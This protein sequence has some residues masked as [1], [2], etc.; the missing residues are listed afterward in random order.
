M[1]L[2]IR[3]VVVFIMLCIA[4]ISLARPVQAFDPLEKTCD[5]TAATSSSSVCQDNSAVNPE[6]LVDKSNGLVAKIA[7]IIALVGGILAVIFIM[8][9]GLTIMTS[10]G[11]SAKINKARDGLIYA[12]V[13]VVVII[14]S[15]AIIG[16]ILRYI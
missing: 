9:N 13:G 5:G 10:T 8:I 4:T 15:R 11:D 16:L 6:G 1:K 7:N 12:A 3:T 2:L 14:M